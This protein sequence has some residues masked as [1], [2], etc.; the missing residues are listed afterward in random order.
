MNQSKPENPWAEINGGLRGSTLLHAGALMTI[1]GTVGNFVSDFIASSAGPAPGLL[2]TVAWLS[3]ILALWLLA[4]GFVWIGVQPFLSRFG[5]FVGGFHL[6]NGVFLLVVLFAGVAPPLPNISLS[7]GRNLL[8][9]FFVFQER[10]LL[11]KWSSNLM[12]TAAL[13]QFIKIGFRI[14]GVLPPLGKI[15]DSGLDSLLLT[16]LGLSIY[17]VG[18][19]VKKSEN[20]WA[21]ELAATRSSG[22][23]AFNNPE[24]DWNQT[25]D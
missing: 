17:L 8:L 7:I 15:A 4:A 22:F 10:K 13:L 18:T 16:L 24:H 12:V 1:V 2:V 21:I 19:D 11:G 9:V 14:L 5:L 3:W 23:G 25:E 20:N 6:L